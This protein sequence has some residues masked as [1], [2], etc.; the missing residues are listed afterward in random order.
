M[1]MVS[2]SLL[3]TE[4][5]VRWRHFEHYTNLFAANNNHRLPQ[6]LQALEQSKANGAGK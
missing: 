6:T 5:L 4:L 3:M 2:E 1:P